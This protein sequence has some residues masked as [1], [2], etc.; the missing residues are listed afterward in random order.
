M[1]NSK[2]IGI[3]SAKSG[4]G[5]TTM[6]LALSAYLSGV[7]R[8][9]T[10]VVQINDETD[11]TEISKMYYGIEKTRFKLFGV[12][13]FLIPE[14]SELSYIINGAYDYVIIDFG[15]D[16]DFYVSEILRCSMKIVM[17]SVNL[18][19]YGDYD[20]LCRKLAKIKGSDKWL[21]IVSGDEDDIREHA[22]RTNI[23][24]MQRADI[25]NPFVM[26]NRQLSFFQKIL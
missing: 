8:E 17:G 24:V 1:E 2:T 23:A 22:R 4:E 25:Q 26:E 9:K 21:H 14:I 5:T 10:A 16:F 20:L 12:D 11:F 19:R 3:F 13:Y 15:R 7:K 18:W 6:A